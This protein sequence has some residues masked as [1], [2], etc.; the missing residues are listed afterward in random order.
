MNDEREG[1]CAYDELIAYLSDGEVVHAV[2]FGAWGWSSTPQPGAP[3]EPGYNEPDP[4]PVPFDKRG[5]VLSLE[6]A[7]PFM[8][9]WCF[10]GGYGAP[11]CYAVRIWTTHRIIWVTQYDGATC[12]DSAPRNPIAHVPDM[13]GG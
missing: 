13:P 3:W 7:R 10:I 1:A 4:P 9:N 2:V 8:G 6:E 5:V 11:E 12:F